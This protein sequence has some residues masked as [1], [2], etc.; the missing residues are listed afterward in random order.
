[1]G[2]EPLLEM[3]DTE[4]GLFSKLIYNSCGIHL[5]E[6]KKSLLISRLSKRMRELGCAS[7]HEYRRLVSEDASGKE[8]VLLID[9]IS[10]NKTD[11]FREPQHFDFLQ[12]EVYPTLLKRRVIR[13]WSS[14]CSTGEEPYTL[15]IHLLKN[16]GTAGPKGRDIKILA[17]DIS[18]KVLAAA[19]QG[20][21]SEDK[22]SVLPKDLLHTY[23]LQGMNQ[24]SDY[25]MIKNQVKQM[26]RFRRLNLVE[27]FPLTAKFDVIFCR[28]VMI[29]FDKFTQAQL[30]QKFSRQ[31]APGGYLLIGH[32][33]SLNGIPNSLQYVR[34]TIYRKL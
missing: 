28:N 20:V 6:S 32:S 19:V 16:L 9:A 3:D 12:E 26:I 4:F 11:F 7:F 24:W 8:R 2:I 15:A 17:T 22:I 21:F 14:A 1:M 33:E 29:Y 23:F 25:Y 13:L 10:T 31:L 18:T 34:S 27:E 5:G 30:I